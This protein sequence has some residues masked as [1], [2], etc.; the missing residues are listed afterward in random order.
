MNNQ[1]TKKHLNSKD[2][3]FD[4]V[5]SVFKIL[6]NFVKGFDELSNLG[7]CVT[8]FGSARFDETHR[9]Y[10]EAHAL[11]FKVAEE[12]YNIITGGGPGIME[13]SNKGAYE[14]D[15]GQSIGLN[16]ELPH[17]Q[18]ANPY[19]DIAIGFDYFFARKVMLLKYSLAVVIFPGGFGTLDE[20]FETITLVQTKKMPRVKVI[21]YGTSYWQTLYEFI[22]TSMLE[23]ETISQSD[24]DL[25]VLTDDF[26]RVLQSINE[27]LEDALSYL[28]EEGMEASDYYKELMAFKKERA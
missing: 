18:K 15:K 9:Y 6:A 12:G 25:I 21:L 16:I 20:L 1:P 5:W 17:E 23:E 7:A 11:S 2:I 8:F 4:D 14:S 3:R 28:Q 22:T 26:E 13:A 27:A 10:K 24:I 19:T